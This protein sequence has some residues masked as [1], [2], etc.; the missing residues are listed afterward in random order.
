MS[1]DL[2]D[3]PLDLFSSLFEFI[4]GEN[5]SPKENFLTELFSYVLRTSEGARDAWVSFVLGKTVHCEVVEVTTR[6]TERNE[7][8]RSVYPDLQIEGT[9]TGDQPFAIMSEHKW[10]S[11]CDHD[12]LRKYHAIAVTKQAKLCFVGASRRQLAEAW[13]CGPAVDKSFLWEDVFRMFNALE[14]KSEVLKELLAFMSTQALDPGKPLSIEQMNHFIKGTGFIHSLER[15][16]HIL[17]N[18][19]D[20]ESV[21][22]RYKLNP[23]VTNRFGRVA[24]EFAT[25]EWKPTLSI[26]FLYDLSDYKVQFVDVSQGIDLVLRLEAKPKDRGN[27]D[28]FKTL[29]AEKLASLTTLGAKVLVAGDKGSRNYDS[30]LILQCP[31]APLLEG[32]TT[33]HGQAESI[34]DKFQ[35][36]IKLLFDDGELE[37]VLIKGGLTSGIPKV[38]RVKPK[39]L[40]LGKKER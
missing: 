24:V 38:R 31:M 3:S 30:M 21:P 36:W 26:G 25:P 13:K 39:P 7:E 14:N 8:N 22:S 16:A 35:S 28:D 1:V 32:T 10:D 27:I 19:F 11:P 6:A 29:I 23:E 18:E 12:Q 9:L 34:R 17:L 20:W 37:A 5:R 33:D 40:A 4:P 15:T 2:S